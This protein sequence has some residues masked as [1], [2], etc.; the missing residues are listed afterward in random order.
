MEM[1]VS[2]TGTLSELRGNQH[3]KLVCRRGV[4]RLSALLGADEVPQVWQA[5]GEKALSF[6]SCAGMEPRFFHRKTKKK[7]CEK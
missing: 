2:R 1:A 3:P 7:Y 4:R 6:Q 5:N